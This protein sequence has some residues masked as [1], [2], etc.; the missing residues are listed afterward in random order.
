MPQAV[1]YA[2]IET[3]PARTQGPDGSRVPGVLVEAKILWA[4]DVLDVRYVRPRARLTVRDIGRDLGGDPDLIVAREEEDGGVV[5]CLPNGQ[6][7]PGGCRMT[8]RTGRT[9]LRLTLVADDAVPLPRRRLDPRVVFGV[10]AAAAIHVVVLFLLAHGQA[11]QGAQDEAERQTLH[12]MMA[13]ADA[14]ALAEL[15]AVKERADENFGP[16]A[17]P[18]GEDPNTLAHASAKRESGRAGNPARAS[19]GEGRA[20]R[21]D[22]PHALRPDHEEVTT[23]GILALLAGPSGGDGAGTSAFAAESGPSALGNIFG[24]AVHDAQGLGGLGLTGTG[25]GGGGLGTG[26]SLG[27]IGTVGRAGGTGSGQ[28]FGCACGA[29]QLRGTHQTMVP[30]MST[31]KLVMHGRLPPEAIQRVVRQSFGRLRACYE[32]GLQRSPDLEGRIA[33]KFVIDREGAVALASTAESSIGDAS[34]EAC[35][36]R[37]YEAMTFPKPEGGIVSVIYPVVFSRT[38]P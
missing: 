37:A 29:G 2:S 16:A 30:M 3:L 31:G 25:E 5:L 27:V 22:D 28:G 34:V 17:L 18:K 19:T 14:R 6:V 32:R 36:A 9:H 23:F 15:A 38:S 8:V 11:P 21:G 26:V 10:L 7:V 20:T 12:R 33:V 35:V 24:Q 4:G 1:S 13:A